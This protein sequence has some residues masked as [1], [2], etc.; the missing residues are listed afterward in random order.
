MYAG[1]CISRAEEV[2][3]DLRVILPRMSSP[4][5]IVVVGGTETDRDAIVAICRTAGLDARAAAAITVDAP[6]TAPALVVITGDDVTTLVAAAREVPYLAAVPV[7]AIVPAVPAAAA[8]EA[9]AAGAT[10]IAHSPPTPAVLAARIRNLLRGRTSTGAWAMGAIA[11][12]VL[13]V[14][15]T[16]SQS[17]DTPAALANALGV[18]REILGFDRASLV[19]H[20]EGSEHAYVVAATDDPTYSQFT[21]NVAD[22][23]E[24]AEVI[25]TGTPV[26]IDDA[27][28]HPLMESVA[29]KIANRGVRGLVVVP[30]HWRNRSL[31]VVTLRKPTP[32][33]SHLAG[34]GIELARM[35][36][37]TI[38]AHLRHG[39]ILESLRDRTHK[40]SRARFE[41]ERRLRGIESLRE[42]FDASDDGVV[43]LDEVSRILFVNRA[44]ERITGF[45]RDGLLGSELGDLVLPEHRPLIADV[46]AQVLAGGNHEPFDLNLSTTTG[47]PACVA[48]STSTVLASTGAVTL[49][50]RDV[51]E[52]RALEIELRSTKEFLE[53]LIDSTVD[54]IVAADMRGQVILF[55]QGA[56]RIYGWRADEVT[57]KLNVA[58]LYPD[59]VGRQIMRMLRSTSYGGV[60][61]LEQ[62][63]R[64]IR[65]KEGELVPVNMTASIVYE[66]DR[67]VATVGIFSDLRDRIRIEQKLLQAQQKLQITEKQALVA[68][69]AGAAAHELNQPLTSII[70]YAQLVQRQS[71]AGAAHLRAV[72]V[73]LREAERMADIVRKIG[74][75]TKYET[76]P[77]VGSQA[78]LDLEK[79]TQAEISGNH[80][81]PEVEEISTGDSSSNETSTT[82]SD[83]EK[84]REFSAAKDDPDIAAALGELQDDPAEDPSTDPTGRK[85]NK[86]DAELDEIRPTDR[87]LG[88]GPRR[89]N[90]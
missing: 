73:I 67:E 66:D 47:T 80:V 17:G 26:L 35:V 16:L 63:R 24:I 8:T 56:E 44:A 40:I 15:D 50:F 4:A 65:T 5:D 59:G 60:G 55:N 88:L 38:A 31:G 6:I 23:P 90:G 13:R 36:I 82:H 74:R 85:R 78:I 18:I 33:V 41:A 86:T 46:V 22:Y 53:R 10:E 28:I 62:T 81:V 70:G 68:E 71:Q 9:L 57:R 37:S 27:P 69:L 25:K 87:D 19:V 89:G 58:E 61:R 21:L 43:I 84:T 51:T 42:H 83:W 75:I 39:V 14:S 54:A 32:G 72:G 11:P 20:L 30:V 64:E 34:R 3:P 7:L 45:A 29:D 1:R 12:S 52:Q 77:Y 49:T 48:V 2:G 79:S 76:M